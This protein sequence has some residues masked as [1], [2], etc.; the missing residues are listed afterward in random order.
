MPKMIQIDA[1]NGCCANNAT[2]KTP[3]ILAKV[4]SILAEMACK[5]FGAKRN[6]ICVDGAFP[7][8]NPA[9]SRHADNKKPASPVDKYAIGK[10]TAIKTGANNIIKRTCS[11]STRFRKDVPTTEKLSQIIAKT[12]PIVVTS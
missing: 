5:P 10:L 1:S 11:P 12:K 4:M 7:H 6:T 8:A 3:P 2:V 9:P